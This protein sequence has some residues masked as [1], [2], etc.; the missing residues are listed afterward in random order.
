MNSHIDFE[1]PD[2]LCAT[3]PPEARGKS[4]DDVR[5]LVIDRSN[6]QWHHAQFNELAS[7]LRRS[8]LLVFNRSRTLPAV[9]TGSSTTLRTSIQIR[10]AERLIDGSWLALL[11]CGDDVS[12]PTNKLFACELHAGMKIQFPEGLQADVLTRDAA[13]PR[14]WRIRFNRSHEA[15]L[16]LL[17]RHGHPVWYEHLSEQWDIAFYQ[18]VYASEPGSAEMPSAGRAFTWRMLF[19]LKR[20]GV[21]STSILLHTGLS[22]YLDDDLDASHPASE[23]EYEID[24][25]AADAINKAHMAGGRVV[26][27]GTTVVR[28]LESAADEKGFI[29]PTH[30]YTRMHIHAEHR[31]R[32]VDGLITGLH[33]PQ[34]SHLDLLAAFVSNPLLFDAY[35]DAIARKYLWHEFG[36]LNLII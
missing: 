10:L 25:E 26:A 3:Q 2:E 34:A 1:L 22:S 12:L 16:E 5:L 4:R 7:F 24:A 21:R 19:D 18:N 8:D 9:L 30:S 20:Q 29:K 31:L 36:D 23:E 6:R 13:I 11:V 35:N 32:C 14:L 28:A 27:V 15:L 17:Y 33:E